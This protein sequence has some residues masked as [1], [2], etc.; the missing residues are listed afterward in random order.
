LKFSVSLKK[1]YEFR[2]LYAKGKSVGTPFVVVYCRRL[3]RDYNQIGIT[4]SN[5]I[6]KAVHRNRIRRR[7]REIYRTNENRFICGFDLVVVARAK[8]RN[9]EYGQL[10]E[11][12]LSACDKLGLLKD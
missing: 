7:I 5:K 10:E 3:R 1:N 9:A 11:A 2:R 4:V 8:S 6:G 12:F